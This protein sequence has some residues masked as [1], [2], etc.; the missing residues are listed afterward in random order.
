MIWCQTASG[1]AVDMLAPQPG[2]IDLVRDVAE[3]LAKIPRYAG[4]TPGS[5]YSVAEHS[6]RGADAL[7]EEGAGADAAAAF[8]LHDGHEAFMGDWTRPARLALDELLRQ[9]P[10]TGAA[11][12]FE[13]AHSELRARLDRAIFAAAGLSPPDR[14]ALAAIEGMD[15]RM[16]AAERAFLHAPPP[17]SWGIAVETAKP[18][19]FRGRPGWPWPRAAAEFADRLA[20][21][22]PAAVEGRAA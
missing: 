7:I 18:V 9:H 16:M 10:F 20:R 17:K 4:Q 1:R 22:C 13:D 5:A 19:R 3:P 15:C 14:A 11:A 12:A 6:V 2:L 21:L 8:L